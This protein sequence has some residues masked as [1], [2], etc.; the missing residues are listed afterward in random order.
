M[1]RLLLAGGT[2]FIGRHLVPVLLQE[3]Y[4][5]TVVGREIKKIQAAFPSGVT[6]VGWDALQSLDPDEFDV[7][8]NLVGEN[9]GKQRWS[10]AFKQQVKESRIRATQALCQWA[11]KL[12]K[13][14][15]LY[16]ASAIG[17]Y[18]LKQ[19][20]NPPDSFTEDSVIF[21]GNPHDFLSD[22][23]QT[24]EQAACAN[25]SPFLTTVLLRFAPVLHR[26]EGV[27]Q[28]M[29][30]AFRFGLGGSIGHGRQSFSW[31]HIQDAI[32]AIVFLLHHPEIEGP[33]NMCS[34]NWVPQ[35]Q[36]AQQ[37]GKALGRPT[38]MVT[39]AWLLKLLF[40][41]MAEE[42]LLSG[43]AVYPKKLVDHHFEF[44]YPTLDKALQAEFS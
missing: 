6:P 41:Q 5:I 31:I 27:L 37:L 43:Q 38:V 9:I 21:W 10:V 4:Q 18:G 3:G 25:H 17:I 19:P 30:P 2:G 7:I 24:W 40:G 26:S 32:R 33:V 29:L 23:G 8:I 15:T 11:Q 42:L 34:P 28:K 44:L 13:K 39:P 14:V 36:F 12:N 16:N 20:V 1:K 22:V 35:R